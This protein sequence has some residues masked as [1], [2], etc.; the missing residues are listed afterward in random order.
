MLII[1]PIFFPCWNRPK[2]SPNL[3]F[4]SI[5]NAHLCIMTLVWTIQRSPRSLHLALG[6]KSI[7]V[8]Q[9]LNRMAI[10]AVTK[11]IP[12]YFLGLTY[13]PLTQFESGSKC[14]QKSRRLTNDPRMQPIRFRSPPLWEKELCQ[15]YTS[16]VYCKYHA[17]ALVLH[18][19]LFVYFTP[20]WS[21][22]DFWKIK[23][24]ELEICL[25]WIGFLQATQAV[26][27]KFEID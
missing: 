8:L 9:M 23:F 22:L 21:V 19:T 26:T 17:Y 20:W 15:S 6:K 25:F 18:E 11:Y 2:T 7:F 24:D 16:Q 27:I 4:C 5:E 10:W 3:N 14:L 12:V 1:G 13:V